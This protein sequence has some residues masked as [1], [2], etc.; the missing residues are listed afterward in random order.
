MR[1]I[2]ASVLAASVQAA[3]VDKANPYVGGTGAPVVDFLK[4]YKVSYTPYTPIEMPTMPVMPTMTSFGYPPKTTEEEPAEKSVSEVSESSSE[5][6]A[7][8]I[9]VDAMDEVVKPYDK[10]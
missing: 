1:T 9:V 7:E 2:F 8:E 3:T 6:A 4:N 5:A 10:V